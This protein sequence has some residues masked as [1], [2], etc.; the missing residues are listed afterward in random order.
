MRIRVLVLCL[1]GSFAPPAVAAAQDGFAPIF[2]GKT[3]DGWD[4]N[5]DHWKVEDGCITGV[6][7]AEAPAKGNTFCIWRGGDVG[8]FEITLE[9]KI[10]GNNSG[11]Q[12]RSVENKTKWSVGGY[13]ADMEAGDTFSGILYGEGFG[14]ILANRGQKTVVR[15]GADGKPV[16][17]V[18]GSVGES[19]EI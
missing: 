6:N 4:G 10:V 13:L 12:D 9:Y 5:S 8:D 15:A 7:S 2:D 17:D 14:G 16:V 3:L 11:I 18:V 19:K 1:I